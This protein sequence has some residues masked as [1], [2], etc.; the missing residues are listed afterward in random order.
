MMTVRVEV[1]LLPAL[2]P[3]STSFDF[4]AAVFGPRRVRVDGAILRRFVGVHS[5]CPRFGGHGNYPYFLQQ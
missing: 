2:V 3:V 5:P 4:A 1:T